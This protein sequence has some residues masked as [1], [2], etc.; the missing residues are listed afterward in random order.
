MLKNKITDIK[1]RMVFDSRGMPTVEADIFV[2][3]QF[4]ASAIAPSG[5]SKGKK[6]ALEK[7]D[8]K[9]IFLGNSVNENISLINNE[10][11]NTLI[12]CTIE[13][14]TKIDKKLIEL[15]GTSN[16]SKLGSNTTIAVS[17]A[18]LRSASVSNKTSLWEYLNNSLEAKLPL[19]EI[20]IIG[21]GAHARGSIPFQDFMI[22]PNGASDFFTALHWVF[23]IYKLAGEKLLS[24]KKLYGV[25]DE[26]GYWPNFSNITC[27]LDFLTKI[28]EEAGFKPFKEVSISLDIAANNFKKNNKYK[29]SEKE[30]ISSSELCEI[31]LKL[32]NKYPIISIEDPFA[33]EDIKYFSKLK[34]KAPPHLQ[35]VGDDLVVTNTELIKRAYAQ[36]AINTVLIKPNQIGTISETLSALKLSNKLGLMSI[37]SARSGESEDNFISDLSVGWNIKQL[38]VGSFSRSER[39][40]KWNQCLRIGEKFNNKYAMHNIW[41]F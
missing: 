25:A 33:E 39:L 15:D 12:G 41:N 38:K 1:G 11:K 37:L 19:P 6:E 17:M 26:G 16:K 28:I 5:A 8:N 9:E 2:N 10:I 35:I 34:K 24:E 29:I 18:V 40:S 31:L 30:S 7:K 4:C 13:D 20:Q 14:Q 27:V 23:K 36:N 22:V 32:I 21:G 3:N